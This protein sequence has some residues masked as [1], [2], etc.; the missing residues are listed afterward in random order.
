MNQGNNTTDLFGLLS[1]LSHVIVLHVVKRFALSYHQSRAA[2][3]LAPTQA[4][5]LELQSVQKTWSGTRAR[6][7]I[8]NKDESKR[9]HT[10]KRLM[11]ATIF[12]IFSKGRI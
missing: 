9:R 2:P 8:D 5:V 10:F 7:E 6:R 1:F 11:A 3:T 12:M 4:A